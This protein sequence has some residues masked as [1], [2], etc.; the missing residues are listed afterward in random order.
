V[1]TKS[2]Q[3]NSAKNCIQVTWSGRLG[4][5]SKLINMV[6]EYWKNFDAEKY[7]SEEME[8]I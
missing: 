5:N 8:K 6:C 7:D 1:N 2:D 4:E 3:R